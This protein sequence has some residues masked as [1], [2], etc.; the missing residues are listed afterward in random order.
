MSSLARMRVGARLMLGFGVVLALMLIMLLIGLSRMSML[1][2][3]LEDIIRGDYAKITQLNKMRD[4]VRFRGIALRDMV[5]QD[6]FGFKR[7]E[8][9]RMREARQAYQQAEAAL[10]ELVRDE[11][12]KAMLARIKEIETGAAE[13]IEVV[14]DATLSDDDETARTGIR[15]SVRGMQRD[16]ISQLDAMLTALEQNSAAMAT[17]AKEAYDAARI[18]MLALGGLALIAGVAVALFLTRDLTGRL[19]G[20]V[21][22]ARRVS[23]GDLSGQVASAGADEVAQ[24][25]RSL[26]Q[27][28]Q[29][30]ADTI[31]DTATAARQVAGSAETLTGTIQEVSDLAD[32][33]TEQVMRVSAAMEQMGVSIAEVAEDANAVAE[34]ANRARDV[35]EQGNR[36]MQQS[37]TATERIVDSVATSSTAIAELSEQITRISQVTQVI[38][39]IADQTNLLALNAAIEAARAGEQGRGFAVVADEVRKLA[40]RTSASTLS[41]TETVDSVSSKTQQVVDAMAH[42]SNDVNDNAAISQTTRKLLDDIVAA[43]SEVDRLIRHIAD[44]TREQTK[45]SQSTAVSMERISQISE[46]NGARL[47]GIAEAA[48]ELRAIAAGL[49]ARVGR[50]RLE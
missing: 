7:D 9:K 26:E 36:N 12:G 47:H 49:Q 2:A 39:D 23:E 40:E 13:R 19:D 16:L 8:S 33:Q 24:L 43:A 17:R 3:N 10:T 21:R 38:R 34:A 42:V 35:A 32:G 41:I 4:A 46:S 14:I 20:A 11:E 45:A 15:D 29:A 48:A 50:F 6:D 18:L 31:G 28:N 5:L 37:V 22:F 44:A 27:M 30:L 1:Q 25:L